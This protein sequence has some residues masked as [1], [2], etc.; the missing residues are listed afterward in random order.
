MRR[1]RP[2]PRR[3]RRSRTSSQYVK[4]GH[5]DGTIFHRV[6][7]GF[8]IQGGGF[9]ADMKREADARADPERKPQR[10]EERRAARWPWRAPA[11][12]TRR[13]RSS[14]S[15]SRTTTSSNCRKPRRLRLRGV[16]QG[17]RGHGRGRQ[18]PQGRHRHQGPHADVPVEPVVIKTRDACWRSDDDLQAPGRTAHQ[19]RHDQASSSTPR[20]RRRRSRTSWRT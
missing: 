15:T 10:P 16:R 7:D 1:A 20:R 17:H 11:T 13:P 5:Y 14:S 6:I 19:P 12:R 3:R 9:T 4:A 2:R 18:D 8:M